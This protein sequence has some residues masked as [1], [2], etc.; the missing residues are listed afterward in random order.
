[1]PTRP[2]RGRG[3]ERRGSVGFLLLVGLPVAL[4]H[5]SLLLGHALGVAEDRG[6]AVFVTVGGVFD[7]LLL[8]LLEALGLAAAGFIDRTPRF[9]SSLLEVV[10]GVDLLHGSCSI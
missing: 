3:R 2:W 10:D 5:R 6:G 1:M 9:S 4:L 8:G 7:Q